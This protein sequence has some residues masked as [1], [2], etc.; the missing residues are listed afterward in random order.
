MASA[1]QGPIGKFRLGRVIGTA[2]A[3]LRRNAI[4]SIAVSTIFFVLPPV[5]IDLSIVTYWAKLANQLGAVGG[6]T[7]AFA[8]NLSLNLIA[9]LVGMVPNFLGQA[10]LARATLDDVN[11]NRPSVGICIQAALRQLLPVLS[12]GVVFYFGVFFA[13]FGSS[14]GT[15]LVSPETGGFMFLIL[16]VFVVVWGVGSS[17]AIPVAVREG[18]ATV[19]SIARSRALTKGYRWR[20]F[21]LVSVVM[22]GLA[23]VLW[24]GVELGFAWM[25]SRRLP[26][27]AL[28]LISVRWAILSAIAWTVLSIA[29]AATYAELLRVK[30]GFG[31]DEL[32]QIFS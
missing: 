23:L 10:V 18:L 5:L 27:S 29:L 25:P 21:G 3:F 14:A 28:V 13:V 11:G 1:D 31:V 22:I 12:I 30:E 6:G 24:I 20:I 32:S 15:R 26:Q 2:A 7:W 9:K 4:F 19:A 17:V 8:V 16:I